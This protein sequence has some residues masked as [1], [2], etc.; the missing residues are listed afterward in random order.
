MKLWKNKVWEHMSNI[1]CNFSTS[2][3]CLRNLSLNQCIQ[4]CKNNKN[5]GAGWFVETPGTSFSLCAPINTSFYPYL[6]PSYELVDKDTIPELKNFDDKGI[7][8]SITTKNE[9]ISKLDQ[10]KP[11]KYGDLF[12]LGIPGT[13]L[14]IRYTIDNEIRWDEAIENLSDDNIAFSLVPINPDKSGQP[15]L[16]TDEFFLSIGGISF[17]NVS[18]GML[19][20]NYKQVDK[21]DHSFIFSFVPELDIFMCKDGK[22]VSTS[23]SKVLNVPGKYYRDENCWDNCSAVLADEKSNETKKGSIIFI[24]VF[25]FL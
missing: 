6:N 12:S 3:I 9:I 15:V 13:N 20:I 5:C 24:L 18:N 14:F 19:N 2:G 17:I 25:I 1:G 4:T 16:Y 11:L 22:C 23:F 7:K 10:F 8:L 21:S